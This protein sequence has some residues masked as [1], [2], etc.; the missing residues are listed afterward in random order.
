M[1]NNHRNAAN[2][3][4]VSNVVNHIHDLSIDDIKRL[5]LAL[6]QRRDSERASQ[7]T[8][9]IRPTPAP[10]ANERIDQLSI[11]CGDHTCPLC[12]PAMPS[13]QYQIGG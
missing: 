6:E 5:D 13:P 7:S 11:K 3:R 1:D 9:M 12:Y 2:S 10:M 4:A 8:K